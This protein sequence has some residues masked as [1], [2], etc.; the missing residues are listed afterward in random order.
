M[1]VRW[2]GLAGRTSLTAVAVAMVSVPAFS[3]GA[4]TGVSHPEPV[5]ISAQPDETVTIKV[6]PAAKP[7][8][9]IPV[10]RRALVSRDGGSA[11][12]EVYGPYLPYRG[13]SADAEM[14]ATADAADAAIVTSVEE[15]PGEVREGTLLRARI[16]QGLS[17]VTTV[18]GA[19]FT[20][21]LAE[22]VE[23][24][25]RVVLPVGAVIE[26]RV[27][28][29]H[30][31]RRIS[32][33]AMMHLEPRSVTLPDGTHYV[34]HAQLIDTD[35]TS[36]NKV[37]REGTLIRRSHPRET[38]AVMGLA[39]G[40]AATAGAMLGGGV[41]AA[42]GAGIGAGAGTILWLKQD[43]QAALPQDTLLV[44]SLT[45]AMPLMP[46]GNAPVSRLEPMGRVSRQAVMNAN[47]GVVE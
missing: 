24:N 17:T 28:E 33:A 11:G 7:S 18:P 38:L 22:A 23:K 10:E 16:K 40:S 45:E 41:G 19:R 21:E 13:G 29:V 37:D 43:R 15:R 1:S 35:Q 36:R 39:T 42:V 44:F 20:A 4:S 34:I 32:G 2:S 27:T 8:A 30:G 9:A 12:G 6:A 25:G 31:G 14:S 26:G 3:Q 47:G 5:I 46:V